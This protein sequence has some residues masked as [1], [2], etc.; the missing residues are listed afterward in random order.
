MT[1]SK[2]VMYIPSK[3]FTPQP[4][5]DSAVIIFKPKEKN[6]KLFNINILEEITKILFNKK[7]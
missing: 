1:D 2:I 5:I 7:T 4:K 6:K 3:A